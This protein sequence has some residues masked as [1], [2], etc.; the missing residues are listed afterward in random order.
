MN[1]EVM[2]QRV[3]LQNCRKV[4]IK[5]SEGKTEKAKGETGYKECDENMKYEKVARELL[6]I[7]SPYLAEIYGVESRGNKIFVIEEMVRGISLDGI[8]RGKGKPIGWNSEF[9]VDEIVEIGI[10]VCRGL[11]ALHEMNPPVIH[12]DIK[13]E[14]IL[15]TSRHP[16][17]VKLIDCDDGF[18]W[19]PGM[20]YPKMKGTLGFAAP[21]QFTGSPCDFSVDQYALARTLQFLLYGCCKCFGLKRK[22]MNEII[23]KATSENIKDR[24]VTVLEMEKK[25]RMMK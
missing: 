1:S 6:R 22:R 25:L 9:T 13:P 10:R 4:F 20:R 8:L 19:H 11:R 24:Y 7:K 18:I 23:A 5:T 16:I 17:R 2:M 12:G 15:L 3:L 14:N 21:E